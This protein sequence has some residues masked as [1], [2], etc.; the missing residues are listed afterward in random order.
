MQ[1]IAM[2]GAVFC[3][4]RNLTLETGTK[5]SPVG[6]FYMDLGTILAVFV[7]GEYSYYFV[8]KLFTF[9]HRFSRGF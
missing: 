6:E 1:L 3:L 9:D 4:D 7:D 8:R 5:S 2:P